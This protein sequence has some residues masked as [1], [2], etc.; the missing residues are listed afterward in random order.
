MAYSLDGFY[1][2]Q[3]AAGLRIH[4]YTSADLEGVVAASGYF[5]GISSILTVGDKIDCF[6]STTGVNYGLKVV[7]IASDVVT[8]LSLQ[9]NSIEVVTAA[10][11]LLGAESGTRFFLNNAT[12][13]QTTLPALQL[14]LEFWF[15]MGATALSSGNHTIIS[16]PAAKIE[17]SI[18]CPEAAAVVCVAAA[19]SINFIDALAV[20]GDF[21]H[22][23]CDGST[24]YL[25][26]LCFDQAGMTTST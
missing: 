13:F 23:W 25:D 2:D 21:A 16:A 8:T 19:D 22:V 18:A 20:P 11:V 9:G 5:D 26:G 3:R 10:N 12:G 6:D 15:Y 1:A 24:W 7:D 14:G 17:G 4:T